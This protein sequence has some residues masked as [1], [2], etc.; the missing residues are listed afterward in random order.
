MRC[1]VCG[2]DNIEGSVYCED[3]GARL[4]V[5]STPAPAPAYHAPAPS[6]DTGN[7]TQEASAPSIPPAPVAPP[8]TPPV[9][10][11]VAAPEPAP[12][13]SGANITCGACG[14]VN[15]PGV[16]FCE[17]CG[18]SLSDAPPP[19]VS[20]EFTPPVSYDPAPTQP[21]V[22]YQPQPVAPPASQPRLIHTTGKEFPLSKDVILMGRRSPV[23]GIFPEVDLTDVDTESYISRKHGRITR[24][25]DGFVFEDLGSSNGSFYNGTR[26]QANVQ[27]VLKEGDS[28]RL[29][30]TELL[31]RLH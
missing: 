16:A 14:A 23:D 10:S 20:G 6:V 4:P 27:Q 24:N 8:P 7:P 1:S 3:C 21:P 18:A 5:A 11:P 9:P 25:E 29:G 22:S 13:P 12:T 26:V 19:P 15:P 17:D 2:A 28:L 31:V 30:K